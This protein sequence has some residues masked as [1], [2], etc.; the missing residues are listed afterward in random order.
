M[1]TDSTAL[2]FLVLALSACGPSGPG[3]AITDASLGLV[4]AELDVFKFDDGAADQGAARDDGELGQRAQD[5]QRS[6]DM[7]SSTDATDGS[8]V[9]PLPAACTQA[10]DF[11]FEAEQLLSLI[12][13]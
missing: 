7:N 10:F 5:I 11:G 9:A 1:Q 6:D 3:D 4:D 13:I 2:V 12:H 8:A